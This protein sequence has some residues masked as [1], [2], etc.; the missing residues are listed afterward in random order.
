M[1]VFGSTAAPPHSAPPS[2]PGNISVPSTLGGSHGFDE[3][4]SLKRFNIP[5]RDEDEILLISSLLKNCL[6]NGEG[7]SG[8]GCVGQ[9]FSPSRS[10]AGT[11]VSK[12]GNSGSPDSL[13]KR[14]I[15]PVLVV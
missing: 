11:S 3:R 14:K 8:T 4:I 15:C 10:E 5:G 6:A 9:A 1:P 7:F 12:I 13:S 2:K